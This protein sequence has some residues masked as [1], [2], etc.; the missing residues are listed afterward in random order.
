MVGIHFLVKLFQTI[1]KNKI[2]RKLY[3]IVFV[4]FFY[5]SVAGQSEYSY[6]KQG[7]RFLVG[8]ERAYYG[9]E[10][11]PGETGPF[12]LKINSSEETQNLGE[13]FPQIGLNGRGL[14]YDWDP[15]GIAHICELEGTTKV[16]RSDSGKIYAVVC[17]NLLGFIEA[18]EEP[19]APAKVE[20]KPKPKPEAEQEEYVPAPKKEVRERRIMGIMPETEFMTYICFW[21]KYEA[22]SMLR[23][24]TQQE[25]QVAISSSGY[26][27]GWRICTD[28]DLAHFGVHKPSYQN[29][30]V[31][32]QMSQRRKGY[33]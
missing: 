6:K 14:F 4:I 16:V 11:V 21:K 12:F 23:Y 33:R 15:K 28:A 7:T 18:F 17:G 29:E 32:D 10:K 9:S 24:V 1:K 31:R 2:M 22:P 19:K 3:F 5:F 30:I 20:R 8:K 27:S 26:C 13:I 25:A